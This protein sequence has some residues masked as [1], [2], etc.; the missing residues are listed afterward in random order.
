MKAITTEQEYQQAAAGLAVFK[1]G[2]KT[3]GPC[4]TIQ[5]AME[6]LAK[7]YSHIGFYTVDME[8]AEVLDKSEV[9]SL[10]TFLTYSGGAPVCKLVGT[11]LK[12]IESM[13]SELK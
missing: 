1:F 13:L 6:R 4:K 9:T 10:P 5:P 2:R 12:K 8:D 7:T 3:C 11:D